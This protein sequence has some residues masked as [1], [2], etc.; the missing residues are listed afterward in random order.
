M[1]RT[2]RQ[3]VSLGRWARTVNRPA[4]ASGEAPGRYSRPGSRSTPSRGYPTGILIFLE[5]DDAQTWLCGC[6]A[7]STLPSNRVRQ[8]WV[9]RILRVNEYRP[10]APVLSFATTPLPTWISFTTELVAQAF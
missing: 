8:L 7:F 6:T 1:R 5:A 3:T 10:R 4:R 2:A 9:C